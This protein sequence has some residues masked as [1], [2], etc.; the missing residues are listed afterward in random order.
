ML[1]SC[2]GC[3]SGEEGER[4]REGRGRDRRVEDTLPDEDAI[5]RALG[6]MGWGGI[7]KGS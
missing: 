1:W 4:E 5:E 7:G 6:W 3:T 2:I